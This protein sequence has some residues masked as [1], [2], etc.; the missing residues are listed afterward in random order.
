MNLIPHHN[1]IV[2]LFLKNVNTSLP[3]S[4]FST[5]T[6]PPPS[7]TPSAPSPLFQSSFPSSSF[8]FLHQH[9]LSTLA[10][11]KRGFRKGFPLPLN[12]FL[13]TLRG[14]ADEFVCNQFDVFKQTIIWKAPRNDRR[15][16]QPNHNLSFIHAPFIEHYPCQPLKKFPKV[17]KRPG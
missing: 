11:L 8:R 6:S 9:S 14:S 2:P 7:T 13:L 5:P 12:R 10:T 17:V 4:V 3:S 15:S 16:Q 1:S